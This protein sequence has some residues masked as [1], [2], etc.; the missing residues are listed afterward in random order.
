M[1][2]RENTHLLLV[3]KHSN[4]IYKP[5]TITVVHCKQ[6]ASPSN[7]ASIPDYEYKWMHSHG[8]NTHMQGRLSRTAVNLIKVIIHPTVD[9]S[10][11][12]ASI[13]I[14]QTLVYIIMCC[15][16]T[17]LQMNQLNMTKRWSQCHNVSV[18]VLF[19]LC[20]YN[21]SFSYSIPHSQYSKQCK[22][23]LPNRHESKSYWTDVTFVIY[24]LKK[25]EVVILIPPKLG[26]V[27]SQDFVHS[28][29]TNLYVACL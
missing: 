25:P 6:Q 27:I 23:S 13:A 11:G 1:Y 3:Q 26:R 14:H 19:L 29:A 12:Y 9:L 24:S 4:F 5:W 15:V 22:W 10:P 18:I 17:L 20:Y 8:L 2:H 21:F 7:H 16:W 28:A